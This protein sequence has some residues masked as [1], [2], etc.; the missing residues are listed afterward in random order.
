MRANALRIP[1]DAEFCAPAKN[2]NFQKVLIRQPMGVAWR[3]WSLLLTLIQY[4]DYGMS[5]CE[6]PKPCTGTTCLEEEKKKTTSV[7]SKLAQ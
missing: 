7:S 3:D 4:L 1:R 6:Q 5:L 2:K